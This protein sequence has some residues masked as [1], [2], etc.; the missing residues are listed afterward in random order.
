M[1][2][3][4]QETLPAEF[5]EALKELNGRTYFA[6]HETLEALWIHERGSIRELYQGVLQIAVGCYHL[7]ERANWVGAV[8]KLDAGARRIE[9]FGVLPGTY[10][11]PWRELISQADRLQAHLRELGP[12]QIRMYDPALLPRIDYAVPVA[13]AQ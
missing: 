8:N 13:N 11:V 9:R 7:T 3:M 10:G 1:M 6:C 12:E 4:R 2:V 5:Y